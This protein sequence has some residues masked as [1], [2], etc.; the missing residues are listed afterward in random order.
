MIIN[1][2]TVNE[3]LNKAINILKE[4][5]PQFD[6]KG[7]SNIK[8][9][10]SKTNWGSVHKKNGIYRLTVSDCFNEINDEK[11]AQIRFTS[12]LIYELIH[13]IP[14][15]WDHKNGFK[16]IA[17]YVNAK[18]PEYEICRATA[19]TKYGISRERRD[20]TW[21]V[22]CETCSKVYKYRKAPKYRDYI[23]SCRCGRCNSN[24]LICMPINDFKRVYSTS[25]INNLAI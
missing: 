22:Y 14:G 6:Y 1:Y 21:M 25:L 12:M 19:M 16:R 8:I 10:H 18:Y 24:K 23:R 9:G 4:C 15:C 2:K 17:S 20:F 3:Y 11:K 7:F 13:T 5:Y